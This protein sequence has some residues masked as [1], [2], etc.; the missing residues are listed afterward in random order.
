MPENKPEIIPTNTACS[1]ALCTYN[2]ERYLA[3]LLDSLLNQTHVPE[4]LVVVDDCSTDRT[5]KIL[6][7][8]SSK[9]QDF[10]LIIQEKNT[11]PIEAFRLAIQHTSHTRIFLADQDDSWHKQKIE[12][13]LQKSFGHQ[14]HLPLLVF[15]DLEVVNE[16]GEF[17][18]SS[19]W[20]MAGLN[21]HQTTFQSLMFG[22][23]VT[24]CASMINAGMR[25]LLKTIPKG[26]LMHD[27]WIALIAY[28]LGHVE[29]VNESLVSYRTHANSVTSKDS[30]DLF[31]KLKTQWKQFWKN[32]DSFLSAEIQQMIQFEKMFGSYLSSE[33]LA[34]LKDFVEMESHSFFQK[35]LKSL[36]KY[37]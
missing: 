10:K 20:K 3:E 19:F 25:E 24:G 27:H 16:E 7:D 30:V 11:G 8:Y 31:W 13:M 17:L 18:H 21:P 37:S 2:G 23:T 6:Q 4:E 29:I 28:G 9:F 15:S 26:V 1:V 34:Y 22:N 14:E 33:N 12:A 5:V 35:K 32:S 36:K